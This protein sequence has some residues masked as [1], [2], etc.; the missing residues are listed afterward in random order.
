MKKVNV[1][2]YRGYAIAGRKHNIEVYYTLSDFGYMTKLYTDLRTGE[3]YALE[4]GDQKLAADDINEILGTMQCP[5]T[6]QLLSGHLTPYPQSFL[7]EETIGHFE[8]EMRI[9]LDE[10]SLICKFWEL[11]IK[12]NPGIAT[13][14]MKQDAKH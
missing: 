10:Q 8:P 3:I 5:I 1:R 13:K 12:D 4:I 14:S 6:N 11:D 2:C 9:P 7:H